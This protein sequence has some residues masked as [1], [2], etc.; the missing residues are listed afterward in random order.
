M[1]YC[2]SRYYPWYFPL[3]LLGS[4]RPQVSYYESKKRIRIFVLS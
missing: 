2:P 3:W 1:V 4:E